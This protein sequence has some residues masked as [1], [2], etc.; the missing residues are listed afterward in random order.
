MR[1]LS[2]GNTAFTKAHVSVALGNDRILHDS[3]V[4]Q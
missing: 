1:K 2:V 3:P 4:N